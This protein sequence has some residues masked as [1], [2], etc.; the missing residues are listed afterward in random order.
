MSGSEFPDARPD[1]EDVRWADIGGTKT[2]PTALKDNG[3]GIDA[4][5]GSTDF[6]F[7]L[8]ALFRW[9]T[10]VDGRTPREFDSLRTA[11]N[12][13]TGVAAPDSFRIRAVDGGNE[14]RGRGEVLLDLQGAAG[15]VTIGAMATD[16][17]R[18]Y[19]SQGAVV[20]GVDPDTGDD[21]VGGGFGTFLW[22]Y[23]A[24]RTVT[25]LAADGAFVYVGMAT[26]VALDDVQS[27]NRGTGALIDGVGI[28]NGAAE[29]VV[30]L[31][32]NGD[33][34]GAVSSFASQNINV[35]DI[36]GSGNLTLDGQDTFADQNAA[37]IDNE[38]LWTGGTRAS[39][40]D[41]HRIRLSTFT[42]DLGIALPTITA[43]T[44]RA[45]CTDGSYVYVFIDELEVIDRDGAL[46]RVFALDRIS[47]DV[48]WFSNFGVAD[49][50]FCTVDHAWL[51]VGNTGA[52]T[53]V[54]DKANGKALWLI[55]D[56]VAVAADGLSIFGTDGGTDLRK[57]ANGLATV[58]MQAV[59]GTDIN[60]RPFFNLAVPRDEVVS[61]QDVPEP[62]I[63]GRERQRDLQPVLTTTAATVYAD[64]GTLH[65]A[66]TTEVLAGGTYR[67]S[68]YYV[69]R[70]S[71]NNANNSFEARV[72]VDNGTI[73]HTHQQQPQNAV[74]TQ[75]QI[76]SGFDDV[77]LSAAAHTI[78]I[79]LRAIGA[80]S[81]SIEESRIEIYR[82]A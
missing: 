1:L 40:N 65:H 53:F 42:E 56:T 76:V 45:I 66:F 69:W 61:S 15:A 2:D 59:L 46:A 33:K 68:W 55:A 77:A 51:Y 32:S 50:V 27:L 36:D 80:G 30:A 29:T 35:I 8:N 64:P 13:T 41:V 25:A 74:A 10:H 48:V 47:G 58:G 39:L 31:A 5:P 6:N 19:Y 52:D 28:F 3:Y 57:N 79:D 16:G 4:I 54:L 71:V 20:Y 78:E 11:L 49:P 9:L 37:A 60:R 14:L 82:V 7:Q 21:G 72:Q 12:A 62:P 34:L 23:T 67:I 75:R 18:L 63:F 43:P 22:S 81:A 26:A 24:P 73:H 44:V 38:S 17:E 70:H